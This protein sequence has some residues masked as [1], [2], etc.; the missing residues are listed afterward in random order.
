[1]K[2][3]ELSHVLEQARDSKGALF[4]DH[5]ARG[6]TRRA[7]AARALKSERE[8]RRQALERPPCKRLVLCEQGFDVIAEVKFNSPTEGAITSEAFLDG[9]HDPYAALLRARTYADAGACAVSVLTEPFAFRGSLEH[10]RRVA[11]ACPVPVMRKDFLV[12]TYQVWEARAEGADGVLLVARIVD[13]ERLEE[14]LDA[15]K[16]AGLFALVEA[17]DADD[18]ARTRAAVLRRSG[19]NLLIGVNNRDLRTLQ[20]DLTRCG[21]LADQLPPGIPAVAESGLTAPR[22]A[23]EVARSA[24]SVA[25]IGSALMKSPDPAAAVRS[26]LRSGRRGR[27]DRPGSGACASS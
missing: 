14:L 8:L 5:M 24:Y 7:S 12:D 13:D 26:F 11:E 27:R 1:M 2:P 23:Q 25:L 3:H 16:E 15:C 21:E 22:D 17:F 18:L 10:L 6:S 4:L 19:Q 20:V 9:R